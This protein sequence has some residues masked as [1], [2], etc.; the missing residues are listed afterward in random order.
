M[1]KL[2]TGILLL[3]ALA[4]GGWYLLHEPDT[5]RAPTH[6]EAQVRRGAISALVSA[7]GTLNPINTVLVGS[8][9]SGTIQHLYAD[10]NDRVEQ[11]QVIAQIDPAIFKA[12]RAEAEADLKI[13]EAELDKAWIEVLDTKR[14]YERQRDLQKKKLA[15]DSVVDAARFAYQSAEVQHKVQ[16]DSVAKASAVLEREQV[17]LDYTTIYAPIDGVV[18]SRDV[19][20][21]QTVAASLQAPTLF[22]I[23]NDLTRMQVEADV[24]EAFIG[25]V[26]EG[27]PV[28]FTVFAYPRRRFS[29]SVAQVRLQ[30]KVEAGVVKYN[31][32]IHVDNSDLALKP[33]MTATVSIEVAHR[34][35][36]LT[37]PSAALRYVPPWPQEQLDGVRAGLESGQAVVWRVDGATLAPLAVSTGI[38]GE[39]FTE[40]SGSG[41][42]DGMTIAVP[43]KRQDAARKRRFGLSLF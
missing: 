43:L 15:A 38:I 9:V 34:D 40:V 14:E 30:P 33:G 7:T 42:T 3:A 1:I 13:A 29:G 19:D 35:D 31:C 5:E 20:V 24:D 39:K 2:L 36:V 12:K 11:G 21:G 18:I 8:Q 27:Q 17:N 23:A 26:Q 16:R 10:F 25:Q 32:V 37:V 4:G 6:S 28:S 22:T 41:L